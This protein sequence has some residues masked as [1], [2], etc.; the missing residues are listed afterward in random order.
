VKVLIVDDDPASRRY[1]AMAL[2]EAGIEYKE[3][4]CAGDARA[5]LDGSDGGSFD[6]LLLDVELPGT[7]G[8]EFLTELRAAGHQVPVVF[9]T[10]RESLEDRVQGLNLGADD[11][12]VKPVEFS[13]LVA[14]LRAVLRRCYRGE[15]MQV[16]D[17]VIDPHV[18]RVERHGQA[19]Q[20]TPR[21]FDV[22]WVLVQASGR[23]V[24]QKELLARVWAIDFDPE[25]KHV[26]V[27][28]HRLRKKLEVGGKVMIETVYGEGYRLRA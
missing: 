7:K 20:L 18:R 8:W 2:G 19:I 4:D 24:S 9:L 23:A 13:E 15:L 3:V 22:L 21:E 11:Y 27:H 16:G 14:R 1:T 12:I 25:T 28:V 6:V 10:V 26:E 17:L 5:C